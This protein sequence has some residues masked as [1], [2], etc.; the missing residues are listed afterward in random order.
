MYYYY[1]NVTNISVKCIVL[2]SHCKITKPKFVSKNNLDNLKNSSKELIF[3]ILHHKILTHCARLY[4]MFISLIYVCIATA[5]QQSSH[6]L[7][8]YTNKN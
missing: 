5:C 2:A 7:T 1:R 8:I 4:S 6:N 3:N